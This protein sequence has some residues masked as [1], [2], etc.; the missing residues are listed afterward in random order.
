MSSRPGPAADRLRPAL[1]TYVIPAVSE[2]R[3]DGSSPRLNRLSRGHLGQGP[4][5]AQGD[6]SSAVLK[7]YI[8]IGRSESKSRYQP[9]TGLGH[10]RT[11]GVHRCH[12]PDRREHCPIMNVTLYLGKDRRAPVPI[13]FSRLASI[14]L[15][16]VRIAP[17]SI[18]ATLDD[19]RLK[20]S[21]RDCRTL[22]SNLG[23]YS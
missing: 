8:L 11:D 15:V 17:V 1:I 23:L 22:R 13:H 16:E 10:A 4:Q 14:K 12:L 7:R 5:P 21:S 20:T 6:T 19:E 9:E 3:F 2:A 18:G